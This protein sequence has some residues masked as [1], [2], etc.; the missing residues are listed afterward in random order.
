MAEYPPIP[1]RLPKKERM[2]Q[3]VKGERGEENEV[4]APETNPVQTSL[5]PEN[6]MQRD[7]KQVVARHPLVSLALT[8]LVSAAAS[9]PSPFLRFPGVYL[10]C[11]GAAENLVYNGPRLFDPLFMEDDQRASIARSR[12]GLATLQF[13]I[14]VRS[15]WAAPYMLHESWIR[16]PS[17]SSLEAFGDLPK[18]IYPKAGLHWHI[19]RWGTVTG[20]MALLSYNL[21]PRIRD[22]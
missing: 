16:W 12:V 1:P 19:A 5:M 15:S 21:Q 11:L 4:Q 8:G 18:R 17:R 2:N 6:A 7:S 22:L 13:G 14:A 20:L 9:S 3:T 10:L